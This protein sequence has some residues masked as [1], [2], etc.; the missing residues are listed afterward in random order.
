MIAF[1]W[2]S[3]RRFLFAGGFMKSLPYVSSLGTST[4]SRSS[5]FAMKHFATSLV[6]IA[7]ILA[8]ACVIAQSASSQTFTT[9][10]SFRGAPSDG[11]DSTAPL[12]MDSLDNLYG[13]TQSGGT[14]D[15][16]TVF[17]L[18]PNGTE[19]LL[20]NFGPYVSALNLADG[21]YPVAG[22][23]MDAE[24]DLYGTTTNGGNP[25]CHYGCGMG[26]ELSP[27]GA[28]K[29]FYD[30][31]GWPSPNYPNAPLIADAQG[32][33]YSTTFLGGSEN[34]GSVFELAPNG[35][36]TVL[37][38]FCQQSGCTDG[39][40]PA[41]GVVMDKES[42]LYGTT[43]YGGMSNLSCGNGGCGTVFKVTPSGEET[44]L[45]AFAG[46]PTDGYDPVGGLVMDAQGNLY[47]TTQYGG[48]R[49]SGTVFKL[50]PNG[51]ETILYTFCLNSS[52][53]D[54]GGP[55]SNLIL[56]AQG[57]LYGTT[58]CCGIYGK[59]VIFK[60]APDG[61]QTV[62]YAFCP[63]NGCPDGQN[64]RAALLM[65]SQGNLYG[66]TSFGGAYGHG[67]VFELTP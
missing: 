33:F 52:C 62:L 44:V 28:E 21:S 46:Y 30:F 12:V 63:N 18:A 3:S 61:T 11:S 48:T 15:F 55:S 2:D 47:G 16:G 45:Y 41:G 66:T 40:W 60:L 23:L 59:G 20:H 37:Y 65:D 53:P 8:L 26:F 27:S 4:A 35:T 54:G 51:T 58:S 56:D 43:P 25:P 5:R 14:F 24:G 42:N 7:P 36:L 6:F 32:N 17:K 19:T 1:P 38:S 10:Y 64:P 50:T 22:L 13:T 39:F 9:L 49:D 57:N 29:R 31:A 67:T 34:S